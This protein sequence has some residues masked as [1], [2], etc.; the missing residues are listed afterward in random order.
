VPSTTVARVKGTAA[1]AATILSP[2]ARDYPSRALEGFFSSSRC[3]CASELY[4][5]FNISSSFSSTSALL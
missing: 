4:P 5:A 3:D 1:P 2:V